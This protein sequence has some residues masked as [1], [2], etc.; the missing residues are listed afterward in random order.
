MESDLEENI[1]C[2]ILKYLLG[3]NLI[4]IL[5]NHREF[6]WKL[7][8]YAEGNRYNLSTTSMKYARY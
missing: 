6:V 1:H 5:L 2:E 3:E 4:P 7:I 8:I